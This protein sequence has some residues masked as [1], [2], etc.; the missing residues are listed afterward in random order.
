MTPDTH[1][2]DAALLAH[3][4]S[5]AG[6]TE[7]LFDD[8]TAAPV[9]GLSATLDRKDAAPVAGTPLPPLWH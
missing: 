5:W 9:R 7:T 4:Q 2:L 6:K 1:T 8:L 3:L